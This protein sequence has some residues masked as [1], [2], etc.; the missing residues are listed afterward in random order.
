VTAAGVALLQ[1]EELQ[2]GLDLVH[3]TLAHC[4]GWFEKVKVVEVEFSVERRPLLMT[5]RPFQDF[6]YLGQDVRVEG[7]WG[8]RR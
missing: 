4:C 7:G 3:K 1:P 5:G 8:D 6:G 2:L